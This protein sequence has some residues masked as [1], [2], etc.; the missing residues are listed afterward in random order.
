MSP[1][2]RMVHDGGARRQGPQSAGRVTSSRLLLLLLVVVLLLLSVLLV[3]VLSQLL[4]LLLLPL[5]PLGSTGSV[6]AGPS[7]LGEERVV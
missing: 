7:A 3:M 1:P 5:L 6:R 4:V 2:S